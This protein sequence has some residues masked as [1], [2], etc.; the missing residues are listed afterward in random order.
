MLKSYSPPSPPLV[1]PLMRFD[2]ML[3]EKSNYRYRM[4]CEKYFNIFPLTFSLC[5]LRS[6]SNTAP[7][8]QDPEIQQM[9]DKNVELVAKLNRNIRSKWL[10]NMLLY[11]SKEVLKIATKRVRK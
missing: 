10:W 7:R 3:C 11:V 9:F 4:L 5:T 2:G 8:M 1:R 6:V